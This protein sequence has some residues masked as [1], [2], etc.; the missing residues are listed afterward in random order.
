MQSK[1]KVSIKG[2]SP[3][4]MHNV[5]L[6]NPRDPFT[7]KLKEYTSKRNKT[8][9]DHDQIAK[10]EFL[11]GLYYHESVGIHIP[12]Y[13]LDATFYNG[14]KKFKK[15]PAFKMGAMT[16]EDRVKLIYKGPETPDELFENGGFDD[17]RAMSAQG[18]SGGG[19]I[20][21]CRPVFPEWSCTFTLLFDPSLISETDLRR[22][23]EIG[24]EQI[25][26]LESRPRYGK[27]EI[28]SWT[29]SKE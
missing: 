27:F 12:G 3:L 13:C 20:M 9:D 10:I 6:A 11:G 24:G 7:K 2:R 5:R 16:L 25:G 15:G 26:V 23:V 8:D 1:V 22:A 4:M 18:R 17:I 29:P 28:T 19:K 14:S 21:R